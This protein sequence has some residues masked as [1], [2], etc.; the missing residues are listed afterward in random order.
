[1]TKREGFIHGVASMLESL[2]SAKPRIGMHE[3]SD[4]SIKQD[5][6]GNLHG[7]DP[8]MDH[9]VKRCIIKYSIYFLGWQ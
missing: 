2:N 9:Q 4:D 5:A 8:S 7:I 1:M 6:R 3:A